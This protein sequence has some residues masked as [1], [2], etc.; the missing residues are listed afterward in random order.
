LFANVW[1][2]SNASGLPVWVYIQGGGWQINDNGNYNATEM[3][4]ESGHGIIM[5]SF[6]YRV[7]QMGFLGGETLVKGGGEHN[8]GLLDAVQ[9]LEWVQKYIQYVRVPSLSFVL[10]RLSPKSTNEIL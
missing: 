3:I 2:P 9:L 4:V 10:I 6:N 1:A 5:V 8:V 7:S